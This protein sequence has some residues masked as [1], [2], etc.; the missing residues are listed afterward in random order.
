ML[1]PMPT[2]KNVYICGD[3]YS[4][5]QGWVEGALR[6]AESVLGAYFGI[7]TPHGVQAGYVKVEPKRHG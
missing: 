5:D 3:A 4:L 1:N 2:Y 6:T 7:S